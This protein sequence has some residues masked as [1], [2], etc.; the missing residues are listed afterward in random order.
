MA[1]TSNERLNQPDDPLLKVRA[2]SRL[3][4]CPWT[5]LM[6]Y[7]INHFFVSSGRLSFYG[8]KKFYAKMEL[9]I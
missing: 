9:S 2:I 1:T 8:S 5:I 4:Y 7:I 3:R 6:D